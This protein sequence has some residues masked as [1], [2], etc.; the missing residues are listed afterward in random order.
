MLPSSNH[1]HLVLA[2]SMSPLW[3]DAPPCWGEMVKRTLRIDH[4][5]QNSR[6]YFF[7]LRETINKPSPCLCGGFGWGLQQPWCL[8]FQPW[9]PGFGLWVGCCRVEPPRGRREHNNGEIPLQWEGG[10]FLGG[11]EHLATLVVKGHWI[12]SHRLMFSGG[13]Q[14]K[15]SCVSRVLLRKL[16]KRYWNWPSAGLKSDS[17]A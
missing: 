5:S 2:S 14:L 8:S 10:G 3:V 7:E 4:W 1:S 16:P 12:V 9:F 6:L 15:S 17:L 13:T 11:N